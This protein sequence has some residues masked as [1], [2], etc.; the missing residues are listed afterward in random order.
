MLR[1]QVI[2]SH[3]INVCPRKLNRRKVACTETDISTITTQASPF[4]IPATGSNP[5]HKEQNSL[6]TSYGQG[7]TVA[8]TAEMKSKWHDMP[9]RKEFHMTDTAAAKAPEAEKANCVGGYVRSK[10]RRSE[11]S[12]MNSRDGTIQAMCEDFHSVL[13]QSTCWLSACAVSST[14]FHKLSPPTGSISL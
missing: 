9:Q 5:G 10:E 4:P 7:S 11:G 6:H 12:L 1:T 2:I 3:L 13:C 8:S 14:G